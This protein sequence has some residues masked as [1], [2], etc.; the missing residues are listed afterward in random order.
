MKYKSRR[1]KSDNGWLEEGAIGQVCSPYAKEVLIK[2][3][4]QN[5]ECRKLTAVLYNKTI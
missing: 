3:L 5:V 4:G 2:K 1:D